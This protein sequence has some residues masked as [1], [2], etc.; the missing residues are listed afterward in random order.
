M[1]LEKKTIKDR[2]CINIVLMLATSLLLVGSITRLTSDTTAVEQK[3][4]L[5]D[6]YVKHYG[7]ELLHITDEAGNTIVHAN[8]SLVE[9]FS[10]TIEDAKTDSGLKQLAMRELRDDMTKTLRSIVEVPAS[11]E[12]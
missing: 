1:S 7:W 4:A 3:Q 9:G 2:I 11:R 6:G 5:L 10:N 8:F 12:F